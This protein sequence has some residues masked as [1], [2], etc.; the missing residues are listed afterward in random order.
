[1][2]VVYVTQMFTTKGELGVKFPH[3]IGHEP[4]GEIVA[5]GEGV[6]TRRVGDR[7]GVPWLQSACGRCEWCQRVK[8]FF[9]SSKIATGIKIAGSH[10]VYDCFC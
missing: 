6:T 5:L 8:L 10:G 7:V 1:M 3:T 9:C 4:A 2:P